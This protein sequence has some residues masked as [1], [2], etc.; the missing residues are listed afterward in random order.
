MAGEGD[1]GKA[2]RN[3]VELPVSDCKSSLRNK[4]IMQLPL[5]SASV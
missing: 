1:N 2:I 3:I 4:F 5:L